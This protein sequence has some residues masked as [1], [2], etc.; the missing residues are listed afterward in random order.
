MNRVGKALGYTIDEVKE[1]NVNTKV[2]GSTSSTDGARQVASAT[3]V[4]SNT[5]IIS[6]TTINNS[7]DYSNKNVTIGPGAVVVNNYAAEI[8]AGELAKMISLKL[9]EEM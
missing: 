6:N 1:I 9:A 5:P 4:I 2:N 8:D 7:N 3:S